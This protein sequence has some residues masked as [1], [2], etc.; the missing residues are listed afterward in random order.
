MTLWVRRHPRVQASSTAQRR[1]GLTT[2]PL[3]F[4][5][6]KLELVNVQKKRLC[7]FEQSLLS[8][9]TNLYNFASRRLTIGSLRIGISA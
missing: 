8:Y 5:K 1:D 4:L 9:I 7:P 6:C 3:S 2:I